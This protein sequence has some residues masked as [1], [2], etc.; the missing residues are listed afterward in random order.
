MFIMNLIVC[1]DELICESL[2][3]QDSMVTYRKIA[4]K[5]RSIIIAE[6]MFSEVADCSDVFVGLAL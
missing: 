3:V 6:I 5:M 2:T 1:G 4:V